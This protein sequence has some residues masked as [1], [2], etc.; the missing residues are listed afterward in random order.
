VYVGYTYRQDGV[1]GL[2]ET[3]DLE[4][5]RSNGLRL[6][7]WLAGQG[8]DDH[9]SQPRRAAMYHVAPLNSNSVRICQKWMQFIRCMESH[10]QDFGTVQRRLSNEAAKKI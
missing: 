9:G 1:E 10:K 5:E 2:P 8:G 7:S 6:K 4:G 3:V